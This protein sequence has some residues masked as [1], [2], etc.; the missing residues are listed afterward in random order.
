MNSYFTAEFFVR[1]RQRLRAAVGTTAP[2]IFAAHGVMQ[3]T[4]DT[5]L[6]F[7]QESNFWYLTGLTIPDCIL[8]IDEADEYILLPPANLVLDVFDGAIDAR[9]VSERSG[10]A[11]VLSYAE[12]WKRLVASLKKERTAYGL[13]LAAAYSLHH[14]MYSNPARRRLYTRVKQSVPG[15]TIQ[16]CRPALVTLRSRKQAPEIKA[17][18][19][20]VQI[21]TETIQAVRCNL[22]DQKFT[23]EY[24]LEA[25]ISALF[26]HK[27][28]SG[29]AYTPI[30]ASGQH[31]TTLHYVANSGALVPKE[32]IVIDVG[33]EYEQYA[34]DITR[35]L[36]M[37]PLP[38]RQQAV[39][40]AVQSVQK[41]AVA[42]LKPGLML[43]DYEHQVLG[44][45][46]KALYDL[47]LITDQDDQA[48]I[49]TYYPHA[50]SHF[51][52]LDVHDVGDYN[53]P[54]EEG[55]V[56]T[57]EPGM[58]IPQEGIGVRI[59]DDILIT[60]TGHENLSGDCDY[61]AYVL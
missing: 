25:A 36:S 20:A 29:H 59:E 28:A 44:Y 21:T 53:V 23:Y 31:A 24:E 47:R 43:R 42:L 15:L 1:N 57:C 3:R 60:A 46:G 35:T 7:A 5:T 48:Q 9:A 61:R 2:L 51:L 10:V 50:T 19:R 38:A 8:V 16:D 55:M 14:R 12:G 30:V 58:Y 33:A 40:A 34:A 49:R 6:P 39:M 4:A 45:M 18:R 56:L 17:I 54:L 22:R 32:C 41:K 27:G 37:T 26:R 52:G 13:P 11:T